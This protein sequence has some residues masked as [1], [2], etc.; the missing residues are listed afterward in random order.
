MPLSIKYSQAQYQAKLTEL[1]GYHQMLAEHLS[2]MQELK[3]KMSD[4]WDDENGRKA[5]LALHNEIQSVQTTMDRT[6]QTI[7]FYQSTIDKLDGSNLD[8]GNI[9]GDA[10]TILGTLV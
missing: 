5:A 3:S 6:K 10:I 7:T 9:L 8:V 2:K 4:F 1:E